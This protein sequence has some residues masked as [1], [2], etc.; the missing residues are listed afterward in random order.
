MAGYDWVIDNLLPKRSIIRPGRS[1]SVGSIIVSGEYVGGG[2]ATA[3]ALTECR[4]GQ[5]GVIAAHLSN[6][7]VDWVSLWQATTLE[8]RSDASR[9]TTSGSQPSLKD[10]LGIRDKLFGKAASYFDPFASPVLFFRSAG[11]QAPADVSEDDSAY[12]QSSSEGQV[13]QGEDQPFANADA[14][15]PVPEVVPSLLRKSSRRYPS[16]LLGVQ[17]PSFYIEADAKGPLAAQAIEL[18]QHLRRS[19]MRQR[20]NAVSTTT[21]F[22]RKVLV[23]GEENQLTEEESEAIAAGKADAENKVNLSLIE[24]GR[25]SKSSENVVRWL[26]GLDLAIGNVC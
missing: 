9:P 11:V 8:S 2:L 1:E 15:S 26:R 21:G 20:K 6:P 23:E 3:L 22:G 24:D 19:F 25:S 14:I 13:I 5:P 18:A 16:K 10:L 4:S 7:I 12:V 17:L